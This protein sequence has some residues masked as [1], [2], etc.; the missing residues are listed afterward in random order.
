MAGGLGLGACHRGAL[1][2]Y[3]GAPDAGAGGHGPDAGGSWSSPDVSSEPPPPSPDGG[4][5]LG[6]APSDADAGAEAPEPD[7]DIHQ[8]IGNLNDVFYGRWSACFN[9]PRDLW[10]KG[11]FADLS[12]PG[13]EESLQLG[14]LRID[15]EAEQRCLETLMAA[16]CGRIADINIPDLLIG[17]GNVVLPECPGVLVGQVAPGKVCRITEDCQS[18]ERYACISDKA[19]GR[20]CTARI[21]RAADEPCSDATDWCPDGTVCRFGPNNINEQRCLVPTPQGGACREDG[22]CASGLLCAS[23]TATS[24]FD[25][26]CRP[27]ALGSSCAGNWECAYSYVCAG[28]GPNHPGTCQVGKSV[29]ATCTTY[30]QD[31]NQNV[32]SDCAPATQ[33]LDL[34]GSGPRCVDGAPLG[35][36]CGTQTGRYSG[37]VGCLEGYCAKDPAGDPTAGTC[38]P[39]KPTGAACDSD[40]ACGRPNRCLTGADGQ[41]CVM[42]QAPAPVGSVCELLLSDCGA[43][44]YCALPASFDPEGPD[45]PTYGSCAL[46]I[47]AGQPCRAIF[48]LCAP[49]AQCVEG[50]CKQCD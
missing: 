38:Q 36:R 8:L 2:G 21:A 22:E 5:D 43:G 11:D 49:L 37:W 16:A 42:P 12:V 10:P 9:T 48:D 34:D 45:I 30:L 50:V 1:T 47:P 14:L 18:P 20:V 19:C 15:P 39:T 35:A 25:G 6:V 28:A 26:T 27:L 31:V 23:S 33:C 24:I 41:R 3:G 4:L 40:A 29:G 13:L 7:R 46:A 17:P 32:Y 44:E